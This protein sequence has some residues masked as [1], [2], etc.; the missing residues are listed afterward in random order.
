MITVITNESKVTSNPYPGMSL[1]EACG[2]MEVAVMEAVNELQME[3]L[4]SEHS[5]LYANGTEM[6]YTN[7]A[8]EL[9]EK[10]ASLKQKVID[11]LTSVWDKIRELWDKAAEW[12]GQAI[13]NAKA[14]L[15]KQGIKEADVRRINRH[16]HEVFKEQRLTYSSKYDFSNS[17]NP[18]QVKLRDDTYLDLMSGKK[19]DA[20]DIHD[21][22]VTDRA[23][24]IAI[25]E[26][27]FNTAVEVV[28]H[29]TI[30]KG[31]N[32]AKKQANEAL[33]D[34]IK[35][36]KQAKPDDMNAQIAGL[37]EN[38]AANTKITKALIKVYHLYMNE[39]VGI[40]RTVLTSEQG[41]KAVRSERAG[42]VKAAVKSAPLRAAMT[43]RAVPDIARAAAGKAGEK[44]N[45]VVDTV[46]EKGSR[47]FPH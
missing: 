4:I 18:V 40:V 19:S 12:A 13:A 10:G 3:V 35:Q 37:K 30:V 42:D 14:W 44:I 5:Y 24:D 21:I 9:N 7:E 46:K 43:T 22:F 23:H 33:K 11:T 8:G 45:G 28:L 31:I 6:E 17:F 38:M 39:N 29:D 32:N 26:K 16:A 47:F 36:V 41:R 15:A 1:A 27:V 20:E 25:D 34:A 2:A